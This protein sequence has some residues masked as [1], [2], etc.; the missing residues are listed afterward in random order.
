MY[1][2]FHSYR[3]ILGKEIPIAPSKTDYKSLNRAATVRRHLTP[4]QSRCQRRN[5]GNP[6]CGTSALNQTKTSDSCFADTR[7][8]MAA[9]LRTLIRSRSER[10]SNRSEP[11]SR[12]TSASAPT[13]AGALFDPTTTD[14]NGSIP[15]RGKSIYI[16][17]CTCS[18][19]QILQIVK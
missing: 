18:H 13:N 4:Q 7:S 12:N 11:R 15:S 10:R 14:N 5:S 3:Y 19:I 16:R 17:V 2:L 1:I 8:E 6:L 9:S